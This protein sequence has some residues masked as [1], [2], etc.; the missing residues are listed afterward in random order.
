MF[1]CRLIC[2]PCFIAVII[3]AGNIVCFWLYDIRHSRFCSLFW[4][5]YARYAVSPMLF[6]A[7]EMSPSLCSIVCDLIHASVLRDVLCSSWFIFASRWFADV[8][9]I[10]CSSG[11]F[12]PMSFDDS[13]IPA[14]GVRSACRWALCWL[15]AASCRFIAAFTASPAVY[16]SPHGSRHYAMPSLHPRF[17]LSTPAFLFQFSSF[18]VTF[19]DFIDGYL[20]RTE[21]QRTRAPY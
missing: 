1:A 17:R 16:S 2:L 5:I 6:V 7:R 3:F 20:I 21:R 4:D 13:H 8:D 11:Y 19:Y 12:P 15:H 9:R 10:W 18:Y 14:R